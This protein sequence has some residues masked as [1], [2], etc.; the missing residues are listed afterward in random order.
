MVDGTVR[1]VGP[2]LAPFA[3]LNPPLGVFGAAGNHEA[4]ADDVG[5]WL[6]FWAGLG[7][8]PLRNELV[9]ITRNGASI[10]IA[11]VYDYSTAAPYD[12]DLDKA[13]EGRSGFVILV[14]HQPRQLAEAEDRDVDLQL[15]GHTHGGQLWPMR[16]FVKW[17]N[18]TVSGLDRRGDT[19][20]YT[21]V[22]AGA[23][24]PPVRV[25]A[26]PEI[27]ILTLRTAGPGVR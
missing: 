3:Q 12:P 5:D 10:D 9:S 17:V 27:V 7:I 6:D 14:A 25:G 23:W 18:G 4:Y 26:R 21:T 13:L 20:I 11:G 16:Y 24:G 2:D 8:R 19:Q 22:G 1:L 15:S